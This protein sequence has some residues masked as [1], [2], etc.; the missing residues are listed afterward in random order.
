MQIGFLVIKIMILLRL[1][2]RFHTLFLCGQI[3]KKMEHSIKTQKLIG[4]DISKEEIIYGIYGLKKKK[5]SY[6]SISCRKF[7]QNINNYN[8]VNHK[9]ENKLNNKVNNLEWCSH[10]QNCNFG[11]KNI[12]SIEKISRKIICIETNEI[13]LNATEIKKKYGYDN[14]LIHKCCKG[15]YKQAYGYH[16]KYKED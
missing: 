11:S 13:F 8:E 15:Q 1:K 3:K 5:L 2:E 14:S 6:P 7:L 4:L 10:K 16:W 9:D 12:R